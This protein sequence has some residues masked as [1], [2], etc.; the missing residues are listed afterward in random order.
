[1]A[2]YVRADKRAEIGYGEE[3]KTTGGGA[4]SSQKPPPVAANGRVTLF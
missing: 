4:K 3:E 2:P 1:M